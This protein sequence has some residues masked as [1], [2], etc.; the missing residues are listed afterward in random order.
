MLKS[1]TKRQGK[2]CA[3]VRNL[4]N[5]TATLSRKQQ[6]KK[7]AKMLQT[8]NAFGAEAPLLILTKLCRVI[9]EKGRAKRNLGALTRID[10]K[11][12]I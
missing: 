3:N 2:C 4:K 5:T 6:K 12:I 11:A 10:K 1:I 8:K 9:E 7:A